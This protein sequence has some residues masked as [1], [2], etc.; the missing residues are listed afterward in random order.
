MLGQKQ[1]R[2]ESCVATLFSVDYLA[3]ILILNNF[4]ISAFTANLRIAIAK[5][6]KRAS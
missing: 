1:I 5:T 6:L 2:E 4:S 3:I